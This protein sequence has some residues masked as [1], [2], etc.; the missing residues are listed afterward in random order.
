MRELSATDFFTDRGGQ[1]FLSFRVFRNSQFSASWGQKCMGI[2]E[3]RLRSNV[4]A[5][6]I[7]VLGVLGESLGF[8]VSK[9][10]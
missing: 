6:G 7:G 4:G 9:Q 3:M 2:R 1:G 5:V 8:V 10:S